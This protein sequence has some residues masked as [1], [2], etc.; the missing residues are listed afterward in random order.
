MRF[1][2]PLEKGWVRGYVLAVVQCFVPVA[3]VSD[4]IW[5]NGYQCFRLS[6]I[7][8]VQVPDKYSSF[9]EA[10]LRKRG[11]RRPKKPRV[12]LDSLGELLTTA[13]QAFPLVTIHVEKTDPAVCYIGRVTGIVNDRASLLEITPDAKWDKHPEEYKLREITRVDF[14][15]DYEEALHLVGGPPPQMAI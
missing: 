13:N 8:N 15:G 9:V 11:Q 2:R 5:F 1:T 14:G 7:R 12:N 10:A 3:L 4:D 6:D